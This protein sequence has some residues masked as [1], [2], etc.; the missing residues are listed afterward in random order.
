[1]IK[2]LSV[3]LFSFGI[4][5]AQLIEKS[6][7]PAKPANQKQDSAGPKKVSTAKSQIANKD[8]I[9]KQAFPKH[10]QGYLMS[11]KPENVAFFFDGSWQKAPEILG[12]DKTAD[13]SGQA[14]YLKDMDQTDDSSYFTMSFNLGYK[15][16][17]WV[18]RMFKWVKD[19]YAIGEMKYKPA[20]IVDEGVG[21]LKGGVYTF[22]FDSFRL[23]LRAGEGQWAAKDMRVARFL[24]TE[25]SP[26]ARPKPFIASDSRSNV[27]VGPSQYSPV[28]AAGLYAVLEDDFI[29]KVIYRPFGDSS[30]AWIVRFA[31][32]DNKI[33]KESTRYFN[34]GSFKDFGAT[35]FAGLYADGLAGF[36][37]NGSSVSRCQLQFIID[38]NLLIEEVR[39]TGKVEGL[40]EGASTMNCILYGK[41]TW[42][43]LPE[44]LKAEIITRSKDSSW[45]ASGG[46]YSMSRLFKKAFEAYYVQLP[47]LSSNRT[48]NGKFWNEKT[49]AGFQTRMKN[50]GPF[51][52]EN[53]L[54]IAPKFISKS[55]PFPLGMLIPKNGTQGPSPNAESAQQSTGPQEGMGE[56]GIVITDFAPI[57]HKSVG[58]QVRFKLKKG[59]AVAFDNSEV[60]LS[61]SETTGRTTLRVKSGDSN[62]FYEEN[63]RYRIQYLE[64]DDKSVMAH[65]GWIN[66][67]DIQIF[68][69]NCEC[70]S[71]GNCRPTIAKSLF[72]TIWTPCF[73]SAREQKRKELKIIP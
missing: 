28:W 19:E 68:Y 16:G 51:I 44:Q 62:T 71:N 1:M 36:E 39:Y 32:I 55:K 70:G 65:T 13:W 12:G 48:E 54:E 31:K 57:Y 58:D 6:S 64:S 73:L 49:L 34:N 8:V 59:F 4:L 72:T 2:K 26:A 46:P 21:E 22:D 52:S 11:R 23:F 29:G 60:S 47:Q 56:A 67:S 25:L 17:H 9:V 40:M 61:K 37:A 3:L 69:F 18:A 30:Q 66:P 43:T 15:N 41:S 50:W 53:D 27:V 14:A 42:I 38:S 24:G 10:F 20:P 45:L 7:P 63:G 33:V 5:H 35:D